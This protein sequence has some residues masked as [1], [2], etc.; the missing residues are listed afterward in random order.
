LAEPPLRE[1]L[2]KCREALEKIAN[3]KMYTT[4]IAMDDLDEIRDAMGYDKINVAGV[5]YGSVAAQVYLRQHGDHVRAAFLGDFA[6]PTMRQPLQ[7]PRAAQHALELLLED[8]AAEQNCNKSFP[9]LR[10]ELDAILLRFKDGPLRVDLIRPSDRQKQSVL[11]SG[12]RFAERLM[13]LMSTT[14]TAQFFPLIIHKAFEN[15]FIPFESAAIRTNPTTRVARGTYFTITCS[16]GDRFITEEDLARETRGTFMGDTRI[17]THMNSCKEWPNGDMPA[18][19]LDPVK[20]AVPILMIAGEADPTVGPWYAETAMKFL[21][22]GR[23]VKIR[24]Y[25]HQFGDRCTKSI[26]AAFVERGSTTGLDVS[27]ANSIR[28]PPFATEFP[29]RFLVQ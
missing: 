23:L 9:R 12:D 28:R 1:N 15:D 16:E 29:E 7:F 18:S 3:L 25:G 26:L 13:V 22:N 2:L 4:P 27:C 21:P 17:R 10:E 11:L 19:F 14:G 8:C 20:S 5:S 24:Y 6:T